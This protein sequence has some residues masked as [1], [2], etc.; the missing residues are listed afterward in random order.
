MTL[1]S[2]LLAGGVLSGG[3]EPSG[4][5]RPEA[6]AALAPACTAV[7]LA[8][9]FAALAGDDFDALAGDFAAPCGGVFTAK[10]DKP[11]CPATCGIL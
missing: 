3:G 11:T 2:R 10:L 6:G 5:G 7:A 9:A 8:G 4:L 1:A